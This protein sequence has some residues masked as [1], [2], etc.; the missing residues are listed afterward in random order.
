M[1]KK[2]LKIF[3]LTTLKIKKIPLFFKSHP[4]PTPSKNGVI[5]IFSSLFLKLYL[6]II[7][8]KIS[9]GRYKFVWISDSCRNEYYNLMFIF[10]HLW[11]FVCISNHLW[12]FLTIFGHLLLCRVIYGYLWSFTVIY[13]HL[14]D[15]I[16]IFFHIFIQAD[17]T[18][19]KSQ[20]TM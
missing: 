13:R 7:G 2:T 10:G 12:S 16:F 1:R 8:V 9:G 15:F 3:S 19:K 17:N 20:I 4:S 6:L 18:N 11:P 5:K 14:F